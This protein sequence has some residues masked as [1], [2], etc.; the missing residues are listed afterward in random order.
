MQ[1]LRANASNFKHV[2]KQD[3]PPLRVLKLGLFGEAADE[4]DT[5]LP[6]SCWIERD[7]K[8]YL[9]YRFDQDLVDDVVHST[10]FLRELFGSGSKD[11]DAFFR[12]TLGYAAGGSEFRSLDDNVLSE[13]MREALLTAALTVFGEEKNAEAR[14]LSRI[15]SLYAN[16]CVPGQIINLHLDVPE[17]RGVD[18]STCPNWL[19]VAAHCSGLFQENRVRNITTVFY[20]RTAPGG[21]LAVY[22]PIGRAGGGS[23]APGGRVYAAAQGAAVVID[24]DSCFHHSEQA[25]HRSQAVEEV[26]VPVFPSECSVEVEK[27]PEGN[28]IWVVRDD[29]TGEE[30]ARYPETDLRFSISCKIHVF[31]SEAEVD[32]Y[33]GKG[34]AS[35]VGRLS[36]P[37][38]IARLAE[39]LKVRG[40]LPE[41][42]DAETTPL[43]V[44][45]PIFVREYIATMGPTA[46]TVEETWKAF[47]RED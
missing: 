10:P 31:S 25:R 22:P 1:V 44:L 30:L 4:P 20:P 38:I 7:G 14:R 39:D 34:A 9:G 27:A 42:M 19:L 3:E 5:D 26:P 33:E 47:Q 46:G 43:H 6:P 16:A 24:A 40:R 45:G 32:A 28:F 11:A 35:D 2:D 29:H 18:R 15:Y 36:G 23:N 13:T 12:N 41:G 37:E 21:A 8:H 17:F